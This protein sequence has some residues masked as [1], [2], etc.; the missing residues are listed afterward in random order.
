[1][2]RPACPVRN[3]E[4]DDSLLQATIRTGYHL[5]VC[6]RLHQIL[7]HSLLPSHFLCAADQ[8]TSARPWHYR[9]SLV[10]RSG[11]EPPNLSMYLPQ[12]KLHV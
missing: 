7:Y 5:S 2:L 6:D 3:A 12:L 1:M 9:W 8:K 11:K 4:D 10:Y